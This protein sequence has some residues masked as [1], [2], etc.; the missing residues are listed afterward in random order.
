MFIKDIYGEFAISKINNIIKELDPL[1]DLDSLVY[2]LPKENLLSEIDM[3]SEPLLRNKLY[4]M[5]ER[6]FQESTIDNRIEQLKLELEKLE[7]EKSN[8]LLS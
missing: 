3:I 7:A 4:E 1:Q 5:Y 8:N 2:Y 6:K